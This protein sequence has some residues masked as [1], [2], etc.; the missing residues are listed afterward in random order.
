M[1]S[2]KNKDL[3][4]CFKR[5]I[6]TSPWHSAREIDEIAGFIYRSLDA[7]WAQRKKE[8]VNLADWLHA[9][10]IE[11]KEIEQAIKNIVTTECDKRNAESR[12]SEK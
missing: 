6:E 11:K 9:K 3:L 10:I 2:E 8:F 5:Q 4:N 12:K 1:I 7:E